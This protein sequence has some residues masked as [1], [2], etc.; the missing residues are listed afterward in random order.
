MSWLARLS[1]AQAVRW[2]L[3]WPGLVL[4]AAAVGVGL[5]ALAYWRGNW[6][7]AFG[8]ESTRSVPVWV[9]VVVAIGTVL[10]APSL[11]FLALWRVARR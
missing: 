10:F 7:L 6:A 8:F 4:L 2:A 3:L 9:A 11:A 1:F 5:S